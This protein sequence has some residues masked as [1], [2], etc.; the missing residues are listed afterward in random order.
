[1]PDDQPE[2]PT[3]TAPGPVPGGA[4]AR[5]WEA[6]PVG[7]I[8]CDRA[9]ALVDCNHRAKELWGRSPSLGERRFAGD[10]ALSQALA[11][12][13]PVRGHALTIERPDG[14]RIA[15]LADVDPVIGSDG[16]V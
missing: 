13:K 9:G 16:R 3:K 10:A 12:G 11:T 1:M 14:S 15:A 6:L 4:A 2:K 8:A 7:V 5:S